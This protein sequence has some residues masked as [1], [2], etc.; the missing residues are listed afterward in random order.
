MGNTNTLKT[1]IISG[2]EFLKQHPNQTFI[3]MLPNGVFTTENNLI[4][5]IS[6]LKNGP[7]N[8]DVFFDKYEVIAILPSAQVEVKYF[9]QLCLG[10]TYITDTYI[11]DSIGISL[12][13]SRNISDLPI[14]E[15]DT[16]TAS[17]EKMIN[18]DPRYIHFVKQ[19]TVYLQLI[20]RYSACWKLIEENEMQERRSDFILLALKRGSLDIISENIEK[21]LENCLS[22][23]QHDPTCITLI[24]QDDFVL[25]ASC[26][27]HGI[28]TKD[29]LHK[30]LLKVS[31]K[32][33]QS[34]AIQEGYSRGYIVGKQDHQTEITQQHTSSDDSSSWS[35]DG[36]SA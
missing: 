24:S 25:N 33:L 14:W 23:I 1:K 12:P 32:V 30:F 16:V 13:Q 7:K 20:D 8:K 35:G 34:K 4:S 2:E 6:D 11:T 31:F 26:T 5:M 3:R 19:R 9:S 21:T 17:L 29:K 18:A 22:A 10:T 36:Y 15:S 27:R 28:E